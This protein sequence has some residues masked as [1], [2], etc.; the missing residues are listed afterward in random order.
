MEHEAQNPGGEEPAPAVCPMSFENKHPVIP[1]IEET[2][3]LL[4][5]CRSLVRTYW[6]ATWQRQGGG[7]R[8]PHSEIE[9]DPNAWVD[10]DRCPAGVPF[11]DPSRLSISSALAWIKHLRGWQTEDFPEKNLFC[12]KR[13]YTSNLDDFPPCPEAS[14]RIVSERNGKLVWLA[15]YSDYVKGAQNSKPIYYPPSSWSYFYFL[16]SGQGPTNADAG[17]DHWNGLP[18]RSE[19]DVIH[20]NALFSDEENELVTSW[21][22][23][24][25]DDVKSLV[26]NLMKA[27]TVMEDRVP[28]WTEL[29]LWERADGEVNKLPLLLPYTAPGDLNGAGLDYL[30][31]FWMQYEYTLPP[32]KTAKRN[33][34][35]FLEEWL[36]EALEAPP[37]CHIRSK[38]LIGGKNGVVWVV[39]CLLRCL[40]SIGAVLPTTKVSAPV[41]KPDLF[42]TLRIAVNDWERAKLWC[43]MWLSAITQTNIVLCLSSDERRQPVEEPSSA[44]DIDN[45]ALGGSAQATSDASLRTEPP[46]GGSAAIATIQKKK[47]STGNKDGKGKGKAV[48]LAWS[49]EEVEGGDERPGVSD[50]NEEPLAAHQQ[51]KGDSSNKHQEEIP[52]PGH[53]ELRLT[54]LLAACTKR[55]PQLKEA[56]ERELEQKGIVWVP[57]TCDPLPGPGEL[58]TG[59]P[60]RW[61]KPRHAL[62]D[63]IEPPIVPLCTVGA[64]EINQALLVYI[65]S[66]EGL[67]RDW[68]TDGET[69]KTTYSKK[70]LTDSITRARKSAVSYPR[71]DQAIWQHAYLYERCR[72]WWEKS[73]A[74]QYGDFLAHFGEGSG[75]LMR[76]FDI[77]REGANGAVRK[78][79]IVQ[80]QVRVTQMKLYWAQVEALLQL[81]TKWVN[82]H[83]E[84]WLWARESWSLQDKISIVED[85]I[86]WQAETETLLERL[87]QEAADEW[88]KTEFSE[89]MRPVQAWFSLGNPMAGAV[90]DAARIELAQA[91]KELERSRVAAKDVGGVVIP[92]PNPDVNQA[93]KPAR[94]RPRPIARPPPSEPTS[95]IVETAN[96]LPA[97]STSEQPVENPSTAPL[98]P[99]VAPPDNPTVVHPTSTPN[100]E[101]V[102]PQNHS[103]NNEGV[104]TADV[105]QLADSEPNT[106]AGLME[107]I[108]D[109]QRAGT[110][111]EETELQLPS[112]AALGEDTAPES[113]GM[114]AADTEMTD[115]ADKGKGKGKGKTP[116]KPRKAERTGAP[117]LRSR[118]KAAEAAEAS[119]VGPRRSSRSNVPTR[120]G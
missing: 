8:V 89:D 92:P 114:E 95:P 35:F 109:S 97:E 40:A 52:V 72:S 30:Q 38:T 18:S 115:P 10:P 54:A 64:T 7:G 83:Q 81:A 110:A 78:K 71:L 6:T 103:A 85:L 59:E 102:D 112:A 44:E 58:G 3:M 94:P 19:D 117:G 82:K 2:D 13:V 39:R 68:L 67:V 51:A 69:W 118:T 91:K 32:H 61:D 37:S 27:V 48:A 49:E 65:K 36:E 25:D 29:G 87:E 96:P 107:Q 111:V 62:V 70:V 43:N 22:K 1:D 17:P 46:A 106:R 104:A 15:T 60:P 98:E 28:V 12:F 84:C 41:P 90:D 11:Q 24:C 66:A 14:E 56:V 100:N 4:P 5:L 86:E 99:P 93:A 34:L 53:Q 55:A 57:G 33:A 88:A 101:P 21:F 76:L 113:A 47:K 80:V 77:G 63:H 9:G 119:G 23:D 75:L 79:T 105:Q 45:P 42:D 20:S 50:T 73:V 120:K 108:Q 31:A 26:E 16:Q 74:N 116:A